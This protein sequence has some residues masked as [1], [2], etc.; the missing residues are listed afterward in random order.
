MQQAVFILQKIRLHS[1]PNG[2]RKKHIN[3]WYDEERRESK[4]CAHK[5]RLLYDNDPKNEEVKELYLSLKN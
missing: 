2:K 1:G 3:E 4:K 5:A